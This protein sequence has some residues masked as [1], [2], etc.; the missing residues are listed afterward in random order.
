MDV[1][2]NIVGSDV[3]KATLAVCYRVATRL[4]HAEGSHSKAGFAQL[5]RHC[6]AE[7][8]YVMEATGSSYLSLAYSLVE[9]GARVAVVNPLVVRRFLQM[10]LGKG[11]RDRKQAPWLLRYGQQQT[12][13]QWQ[14]DEAVLVE[15][16]PLEQVSEQLIRQKTMTL[17]SLEALPQPPVG[18]AQAEQPLR[19]ALGRLEEQIQVLETE[20][21]G[22]WE[23]HYARQMPFLCSIPGIGRKTAALLLLFAKGFTQVDT[24]R[25]LTA[26][27]GL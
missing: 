13:K 18:S 9:Q 16:R 3:S 8:L 22:L 7:C 17:N 10:H 23:Q 4:Q 5:V 26:K 27:A 15:G 6:G 20:L 1:T 24:Y 21:V 2:S 25:Q 12:P 14:P 19:Q 11:K